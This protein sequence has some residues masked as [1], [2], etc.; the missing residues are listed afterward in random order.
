MSDTVTIIC[1]VLGSGAL[2]ALVSGLFNVA[3]ARKKQEGGT[4]AGVRILLE[5]TIRERCESYIARGSIT[6]DELS[7]LHRMWQCYH[8]DMNGNGFLN[9]LMS[10]C[11]KLRIEEE[12]K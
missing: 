5:S 2:S 12:N 6:A 8:D 4:H 3:T 10:A 7:H 9:A 1:A 11:S